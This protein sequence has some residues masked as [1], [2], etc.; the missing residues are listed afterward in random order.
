MSRG[1]GRPRLTQTEKVLRAVERGYHTPK[2]I[3]K[4]SGVPVGNVYTY[5][6]RLRERGVIKSNW[7]VKR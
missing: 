3:S 2:A 6:S 5:I 1:P 7:T 4:A